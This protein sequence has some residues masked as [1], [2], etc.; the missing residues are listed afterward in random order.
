MDNQPVPEKK[1]DASDAIILSS[2]NNSEPISGS[3]IE[4]IVKMAIGRIA[5]NVGWNTIGTTSLDILTEV[6]GKYIEAIGR[7][8]M[9]YCNISGR[10]EGE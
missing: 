4:S 6:T 5:D 7:N 8:S 1:D 9:R 3:Y 2:D 10:T